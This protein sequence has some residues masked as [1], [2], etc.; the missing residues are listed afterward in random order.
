M[1]T[2]I[3]NIGGAMAYPNVR[4]YL[5]QIEEYCNIPDFLFVQEPGSDEN[6]DDTILEPF[7]TNWK[8]F[9]KIRIHHHK[10]A[11]FTNLEE[12]VGIDACSIV[13]NFKMGKGEFKLVTIGAYRRHS[14]DK[15]TFFEKLDK[16]LDKYTNH[17]ILL[18]GDF[19]THNDDILLTKLIDSHSVYLVCQI[20]VTNIEILTESIKLITY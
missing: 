18:C 19:N 8:T 4:D 14:I 7:F 9:G 12:V 11:V 5:I 6:F 16:H 17:Y 2:M 1:K 20:S 3:A 13:T 10:D 15:A